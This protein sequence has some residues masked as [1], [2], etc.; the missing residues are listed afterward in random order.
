MELIGSIPGMAVNA[1]TATHAAV[2]LLLTSRANEW[3][4]LEMTEAI[5]RKLLDAGSV[6]L[7]W[8]WHKGDSN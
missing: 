8:F 5:M 1:K 6:V 7:F 4:C 3:S 2:M